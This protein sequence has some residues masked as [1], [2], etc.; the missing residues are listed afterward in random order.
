MSPDD[1]RELSGTIDAPTPSEAERIGELFYEDMIELGV[2]VELEDLTEM[3]D[4]IIEGA[5]SD[6]P[7]C[8]AWVARPDETDKAA[9]VIVANFQWSLKFAGRSIWIEELYV[10]PDQRR[11]GFGRALVEHVVAYAEEHDLEGIDLEAYRGNTP[12]SV[13]YRTTGFRRLGRERFYYTLDGDY[14]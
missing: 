7:E 10:T 5:R 9:G 11:R 12:A 3:A 2:E 13:L 8:L 14:L 1:D 4:H 6:P